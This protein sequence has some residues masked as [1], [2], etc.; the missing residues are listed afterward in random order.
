MPGLFGAVNGFLHATQY[1]EVNRVALRQMLGL[2]DNTFELKSVLQATAVNP[3]L[4]YKLCQFSQ[5]CFTGRFM[6][7]TQKIKILIHQMPCNRFIGGQH[8]LFNYL[9]A[10]RVLCG[11]GTA[12]ASVIIQINHHFG[13]HKIDRS[14]VH[15]PLPQR[16]R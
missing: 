14:V 15:P 3:Q 2:F 4:P 7:A 6:N 12:D 1:G 5:F 8:E 13:Q 11:M 10:F 16:H 9:M